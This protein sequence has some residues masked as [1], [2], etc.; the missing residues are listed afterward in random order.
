MRKMRISKY[1]KEFQLGDEVTNQTIINWINA[2]R[3]KGEKRGGL[4][5]VCI[6]DSTPSSDK[7]VKFMEAAL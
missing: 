4:W 6:D 1:I 3:L 7:L 5:L 2:G